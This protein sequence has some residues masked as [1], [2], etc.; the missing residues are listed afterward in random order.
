VKPLGD[1]TTRHARPPALPR[2][3]TALLFLAAAVAAW[4][5]GPSAEGSNWG[6]GHGRRWWQMLA[7]LLALACLWE[8]SGLETWLGAQARALARAEDFYYPRAL[9]QKFVVSVA[10]VAAISFLLFIRR[11]CSSRRLLLASFA[12]YLAISLV[13]LVSWH[14]IDKVAD[15][16]WHG[17][18]LAQ[19]LKLGCAAVALA[20]A[21][22]AR[23]GH[24]ETAS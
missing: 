23:V 9:F 3:V 12:L 22:K 21:Q 11:T 4:G 16:S 17:L 5:A 14:V 18:T 7:V 13:N 15:L 6:S 24:T 1:V 20:G 2:W 19:A 8:L 10:I